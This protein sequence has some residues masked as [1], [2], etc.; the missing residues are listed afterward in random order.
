MMPHPEDPNGGRRSEG[1]ALPGE[2][3]PGPGESELL[4]CPLPMVPRE[5]YDPT[6]LGVSLMALFGQYRHGAY[7]WP[8]GLGDQPAWYPP[9]MQA[10]DQTVNEAQA[11]ILENARKSR[12]SESVVV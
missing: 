12:P 5:W 6:Q 4:V 10:V 8:G 1:A 3:I 11:L 9:A 2:G 7:P